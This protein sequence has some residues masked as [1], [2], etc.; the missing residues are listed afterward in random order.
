MYKCKECNFESDDVSRIANHYQY[1]HKEINEC[2]CK[3]CGKKFKNEKGLKC[4]TEKQ[5]EKIIKKNNKNH[6]CPK[7]NIYISNNIEKHINCC[8]GSG[9][10]R[11]IKREKG[12]KGWSFGKTFDEV[13]GLEKSKEIKEK[14]SNK[15]KGR[16]S[17]ISPEKEIIRR[18]KLSEHAKKNH[19]GGYKKGSGRGKCGWYKNYW[20]DSSWELAYVIY[21]LEH[22]INIIRN[23]EK[24]EYVFNNKK[25]N[26][27]PDFK[28]ENVFIEI[29]GYYTEQTKCKTEQFKYNL[30]VYGKD[31]MI[32]ILEYVKEKYGKN[33]IELY[34]NVFITQLVD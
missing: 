20:C 7:C 27:I 19:Y 3:K 24:F 6:I 1:K 21:C 2:Y 32:P 12:G 33:F 18:E 23:K 15:L 13:F 26:Y 8:D 34:D 5:C 9:P 30:I 17:S 11:N 22:N 16:I 31:E 14:I 28:I 29:K 25:L 4:H 10:R